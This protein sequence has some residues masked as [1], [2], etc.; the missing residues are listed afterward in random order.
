M[1][2]D[3]SDLKLRPSD[4]HRWMV[5]RASPGYVVRNAHRIVERVQDYT[6]EGV[7]A[8]ELGA[9]HLLGKPFPSDIEPD[10]KS[11]LRAYGD[12][13]RASGAGHKNVVMLVET[14]V[15]V[16]YYR[17]KKGYVDCALLHLNKNGRVHRVHVIDLK[18][19]RGV[20]VEALRNPQLSSY[21]YGLIR[22]LADV[23][24]F[25]EDAEVVITIWQP[26]VQGEDTERTWETNLPTLS[27]FCAEIGATAQCIRA[28]P[29][30]QP[31]APGDDTCTFCPAY[32]FCDA[33]TRWLLGDLGETIEAEV[34]DLTPTVLEQPVAAPAPELPAPSSLTPSQLSRILRLKPLF[35]KW[36]SKVE[37]Y[38]AADALQNDTPYEGFKIVATMPHRKWVSEEEAEKFLRAHLSLDVAAPRKLITPAQAEELLLSRDKKVRQ[39]TLDRLQALIYRPQGQPT[40]API[41]DKRQ[42]WRDV[43]VSAEFPD[44][45]I[46]EEDQSLL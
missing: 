26:R 25:D 31:F 27:K 11:H 32:E 24:E 33:R 2:T 39:P 42:A 1:P 14:P 8:H 38:V 3:Y 12:F 34:I 18:Y 5:C 37:E 45:S 15:N 19:G 10:M 46:T 4:A 20:S 21:A 7:V 41:E 22:D 35:T 29:F 28:N 9:A 44:G 13:V 40:L 6:E 23:Y 16:F 17:G 36:F 30:T 43:D